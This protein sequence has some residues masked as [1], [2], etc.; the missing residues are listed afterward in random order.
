MSIVTGLFC[1]SA[2]A[3]NNVK[4]SAYF[5]GTNSI[6]ITAVTPIVDNSNRKMTFEVWEKQETFSSHM[7]TLMYVN[8]YRVNGVYDSLSPI[9]DIHIM[10]DTLYGT[11]GNS[12]YVSC[13]L[14]NHSDWHHIALISDTTLSG[15]DT[16]LLY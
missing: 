1:V 15:K 12:V 14:T 10:G 11:Y 9:L 8:S 3:Q 6:A 13:P 16:F 7:Q 2:I 4:Q 5:D